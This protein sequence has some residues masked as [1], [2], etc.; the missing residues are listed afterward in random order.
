MG[1]KQRPNVAIKIDGRRRVLAARSRCGAGQDGQGIAR[2]R[3][4]GGM[5]GSAVRTQVWNDGG[6][7]ILVAGV[8]DPGEPSRSPASQRPQELRWETL[9]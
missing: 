1:L 9:L 8:C 3:G 4:R 6:S 2:W 5:A 7:R